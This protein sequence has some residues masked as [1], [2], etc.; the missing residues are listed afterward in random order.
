[1]SSGAAND[2]PVKC[3]SETGHRRSSVDDQEN[4]RSDDLYS[5]HDFDINIDL[6]VPEPA[7][8]VCTHDSTVIVMTILKPFP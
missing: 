6:A 3:V 2:V 5:A 8:G 7:S 1:M 4:K